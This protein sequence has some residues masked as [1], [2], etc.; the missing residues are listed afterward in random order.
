GLLRILIE[1]RL[2]LPLTPAIEHAIGGFTGL[3][4]GETLAVQVRDFILER[5]RSWYADRGIGPAIFQSVALIG[6]DQ[7]LDFDARIHAV[8]HFASLPQAQ[9]LAAANKRVSN[10]LA[11]SEDQ[12]PGGFDAALA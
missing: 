6:S 9:A 3:T 7:P 1:K 10:I 8:Q 5:L 4:V 2:A 12:V 11:K